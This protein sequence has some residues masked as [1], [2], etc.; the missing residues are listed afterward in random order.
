MAAVTYR[1]KGKVVMYRAYLVFKF[2]A[3]TSDFES[4]NRSEMEILENAKRMD[5]NEAFG[6]ERHFLHTTLFGRNPSCKRRTEFFFDETCIL[7]AL[8]C[9]S[10][11]DLAEEMLD[12]QSDLIH[13]TDFLSFT[14]DLGVIFVFV[15]LCTW[16]SFLPSSISK[17]MIY[18]LDHFPSL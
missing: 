11:L 18:M 16:R 17:I 12:S 6:S 4:G 8:R 2:R 15:L 7:M 9:S 14:H 13:I 3:V 5:G 10:L 1:G